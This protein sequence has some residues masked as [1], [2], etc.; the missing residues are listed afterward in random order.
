MSAERRLVRMAV[1]LALAAPPTPSP[2]S[3]P[4]AVRP[5]QVAASLFLLAGRGYDWSTAGYRDG[6]DLPSPPVTFNIRDPPFNAAGD[7]STDDTEAFKAVVDAANA[8]PGGGVILLPAGTYI[9]KE[10]LVVNRSGVVFRGEGRGATTIR[11]P[12]SLSD[13]YNGTWYIDDA[14][15]IH[16]AWSFGGSF[17]LFQGEPQRS[18]R[19]ENR[20]AFVAGVLP[21]GAYRIPITSTELFTVGSWVRLYLNDN[22]TDWGYTGGGGDRRRR[23]RRLLAGGGDTVTTT[24]IVD[25][26]TGRRLGKLVTRPV[27]PALLSSPVF[28]AAMEAALEYGE[29]DA[30]L[31]PAEALAA[32][33][34]APPPPGEV[35]TATASPGTIT[36]WVVSG[37]G[38]AAGACTPAS[39][40]RWA[41]PF[42]VPLGPYGDNMADSGVVN[43]TLRRDDISL[44]ARVEAI[45]S[46][47]IDLDRELPFP[48]QEGWEGLFL[49]YLPTVEDGGMEQL[50]IAFDHEMLPVPPHFTDKGYNAISMRFAANMWL[51]EVTIVNADNGCFNDRTDKSTFK[52][53]TATVTS[54]RWVDSL[55]N[56]AVNGH[57]PIFLAHCQSNL[58]DG[59]KAARQAVLAAAAVGR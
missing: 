19:P 53:V 54:R 18:I 17:F 38:A 25:P 1:L 34:I 20:L 23:R 9:L 27:D 37:A 56:Q 47:Y 29:G 40:S 21:A 22:S 7:N 55:F 43:N 11:I 35:S 6:A 3:P 41:T 24:A 31:S 59:W 28:V 14:G 49:R 42:G 45:G 10:P 50:T 33:G 4:P 46:G 57:H 16:S 26:A 13:I 32:S 44:V 5:S 15:K 51:K 36:A 8:S 52:D 39:A 2:P 30:G 48:I 12:L 58:V